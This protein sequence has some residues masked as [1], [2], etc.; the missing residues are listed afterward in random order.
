MTRIAS[1]LL[2]AAAVPLLFCAAY[3]LSF[4]LVPD[5]AVVMA[6]ADKHLEHAR[7]LL[8]RYSHNHER[9]A[10]I[11]VE[12]ERD[13]VNVAPSQGQIEPLLEQE[14]SL[15]E[16]ADETLNTRSRGEA[17]AKGIEEQ[18]TYPGEIRVTVLREVRAVSVAR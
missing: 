16:E 10:R 5:H 12:L 9:L 8:S 4:L 6:E 15:L 3:L 17:A 2:I 1:I 13:G 11:L 14:R 18:M 7:R